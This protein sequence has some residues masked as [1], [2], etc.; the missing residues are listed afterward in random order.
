MPSVCVV[1]AQWGDE[2]K[3]GIVDL[4]SADA[5]WVVRF[6]GGPNAGHTVVV[7]EEVFKLHLIPSGIVR[8]E[9]RCLIGQ[10]VAVDLEVLFDEVEMLEG[11][12]VETGGR[13]L[14]SDRAHLILPYHRLLDGLKENHS[15]LKIGTTRR[16]IGPCY[17]DKH[18][19]RG[20]RVADLMD[21]EWFEER[22]RGELDARNVLLAKVYGEDGLDF[23][24]TRAAYAALRERL[25]PMV[26]DG[27]EEMT[28]ALDRGERVVFEGAQGFLLDVDAGT[29]PFV[30]GS[31][32]SVLGLPAGAG[33]P[34]GRVDHTVGISKAYCTRVGEGPF[35]TEEPGPIGELIRQ[36]GGEFGTTTGR[37]RRCGWFD[38][39]A[40][41]YAA[42]TSGFDELAITK[43]DILTGLPILKVAV[44]YEHEGRRIDSFPASSRTLTD[45]KP[46]YEEF[47]GFTGEIGD[48]RT[49]EDLPAEAR[50]YLQALEEIV[51]TPIRL[52]SVGP[53]RGQVV[54][55]E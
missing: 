49:I 35:P 17:A 32:S 6:Q 54:R 30:T 3:A 55:R 21:I 50:S 10:G 22:L 53:E 13:L 40:V 18:S 34:L 33:I 20:I 14:V 24:E 47:P 25:A 4:L 28:G 37:P 12:G 9:P 7:E 23:E 42:R 26:V 8:P 31:N 27:V 11:R 52:A 5:D 48:A 43:L 39:V 16:G 41:K 2:G 1:G 29:Y 36:R 44:A 38:A 15:D 51:E 19:Y 45:A 46:V